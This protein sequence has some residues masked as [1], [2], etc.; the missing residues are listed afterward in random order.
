MKD[1]IVITEYPDKGTWTIN[2]DKFNDESDI[3]I[4][5]ELAL[6]ILKLKSIVSGLTGKE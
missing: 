1:R 5:K 4:P 2:I 6:E 3:F